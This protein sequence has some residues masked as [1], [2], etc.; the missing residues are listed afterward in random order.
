[1]EKVGKKLLGSIERSFNDANFAFL[2]G[3]QVSIVCI[4]LFLGIT[5]GITTGIWGKF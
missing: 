5:I 4:F 2:A 1:M 3:N